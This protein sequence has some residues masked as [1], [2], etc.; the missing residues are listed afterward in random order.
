MKQIMKV[1]VLACSIW[2]GMAEL[3]PA[4]I[5]I[6]T[7]KTRPAISSYIYGQF[8]EHLGRCIYGGIWA[9][10]LE[11]RKFYFPVT[12]EYN[13]YSKLNDQPFPVVGKSPWQVIG[14]A[15]SVTMETAQPFVGTHTPLVAAGSGLRQKDLGLVK[16]KEYVGYIWLRAPKGRGEVTVTLKGGEGRAVIRKVADRY[17]K[18]EFRFKAIE[19]TDKGELGIAVAGAACLVG[20]VSL[21]PSDNIRGMRSDTLA[22]LRE[23]DAPI[24]RW[25]GGNFTSGYEWRDGI[26]DRDRRPPRKNPAWTGVEH[27]DFGTDEFLDFCHEIKTE[28]LIVVNTGLGGP[29]SAGQWVEY[30]N[31]ASTTPIGAI[32]AANGNKKPYS[33]RW[34]GIG[35]EM[36]G[37]WQL[38][39][40]ALNHYIL[41]HNET[42]MRMRAIDPSI[43][44]VGVGALGFKIE[45]YFPNEKRDWTTGMMEKCADSMDWISEHFYCQ[46]KDDVP[47]H[48]RL[49]PDNIHRIAEGHRKLRGEMPSL[50]GKDIRIS[51]DE[52]NYW[53]GP[54]LYGELGTRYFLKDALGIAAG[55]HEYFRCTDIIDAAFYA[56]TVN[57]IGC[58]KTTKT[59]AFL[60]ATALPLMLYRR[61]FGTLPLATEGEVKDVD[62]AAALTA[63]RKKI[64]IGV[65]NPLAQPIEVTVKDFKTT[66][67]GRVWTIAGTDPLAFNEVSAPTRLD[68]VEKPAGFD[69]TLKV[70]PLSISLFEFPIT[71]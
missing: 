40:M 18:H 3:V 45:K 68:V 15:G 70:P 32:R 16:G 7:S 49:I 4:Q 1:L 69:G 71:K 19:S 58:I 2:F 31:G 43:K 9:E 14:Q 37:P 57:V 48:V 28:P 13:P 8:I 42:V 44:V 35:N 67:D 29:Y 12:D 53:Y 50:A 56:Q 66:A 63:D 55:L 39:F 21:M 52:W 34:W 64:T 27:N 61:H 22:K 11:D 25:P 5:Q 46:K 24:Y 30:V 10:M 62:V 54:H 23:L 51:M 65:V 59:E 33:V 38:G 41:K 20:T 6:D 36:Y 26:G 17:A 60:D 47:A